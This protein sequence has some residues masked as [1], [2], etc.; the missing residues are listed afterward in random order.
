MNS[1]KV[2]DKEVATQRAPNGTVV[3]V[4]RVGDKGS[5]LEI[6]VHEDVVTI[7]TAKTRIDIRP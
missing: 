7:R 6:L 4:T 3:S 2:N 1:I 5:W